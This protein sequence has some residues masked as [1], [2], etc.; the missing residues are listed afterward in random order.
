M[1][2]NILFMLVVLNSISLFAQN[3][4]EF[5]FTAK[6]QEQH[7]NMDSVLIENI[8]K[9]VSTKIFAPDTVFFWDFTTGTNKYIANEKNNFSISQNYPNPISEKTSF[10]LILS[11]REYVVIIV[12]DILGRELFKY[13]NALKSGEHSFSFFPG[14]ESIYLLI[15]NIK[16][17]TKTIKMINY[18]S[19]H[20]YLDVCELV[21]NGVKETP[22]EYKTDNDLDNFDFDLGD[23]MRYTVYT[24]SFDGILA[25]AE[26]T[27]IP[28]SDTIYS[29]SVL[30]GLRCRGIPTVTDIEENIYNTVQ[31]GEQCWMKENL[32]TV[33]YKNNEIIYHLPNN[34][35]W[36][37][38]FAGYSWPNNDTIYKDAYGA[39]YNQFAVNHSYGICPEGWH[40]PSTSEWNILIAFFGGPEASP[41]FKIKSCRFV[42]SSAGGSCS[43]TEHPRWNQAGIGWE[44]TDNYGFSALPAG[45][46]DIFGYFE[47][48]GEWA[49]FWTCSSAG[50]SFG[51]PVHTTWASPNINLENYQHKRFG[52]SLRC[53]KD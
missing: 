24:T 11:K 26:I 20:L 39:I 33:T 12:C 48:L 27:D 17:K 37:S 15:V 43:T 34:A 52:S 23:Q 16:D 36:Q 29:F 19:S 21:Y 3:T 46:R 6:Y 14:L 5:T 35:S 40:V 1:G 9:S 32:K 42:N 30:K 28:L 7:V 53:I 38:N 13:E 2:K 41:G 22:S 31:I 10:S 45:F 8:T 44:G 49:S 47:N 4:I 18:P 51:Y 50:L 25:S